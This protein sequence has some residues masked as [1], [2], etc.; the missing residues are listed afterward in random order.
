VTEDEIRAWLAH[1]IDPHP[2]GVYAAELGVVDCIMS[3][4]DWKHTDVWID[5]YSD[6]QFGDEDPEVVKKRATEFA[7]SSLYE[8]HDGPHLDTCPWKDR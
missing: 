8:C 5:R 4:D 6:A 3:Q 1:Y 7:L 2:S